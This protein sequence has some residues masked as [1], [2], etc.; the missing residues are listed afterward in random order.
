MKEDDIEFHT[1]YDINRVHTN[2]IQ[3][4]VYFVICTIK[5]MYFVSLEEIGIL[6]SLYER[7]NIAFIINE[8]R[9]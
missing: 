1:L 9:N 8:Y 7:R 5:D 2:V 3:S 4:F 6:K